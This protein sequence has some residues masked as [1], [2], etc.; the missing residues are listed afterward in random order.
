MSKIRMSVGQRIVSILRREEVKCIFSQGELSLKDIQKHA[1]DQGIRLVGPHHEAAGVWM[2]AAYYRMTGKMQV[3]MGA[4]GP[5]VA[6]MLPAV[7]WAAEER[8]PILIVG[9]SR[10]HEVTS[11]VRRGRFLHAESLM[12][13]YKEI[14]K[15]S[16]RIHHARQVDEVLQT[17]FREALSGTPGPV[18]VE[19]DYA[20]QMDEWD[21]G[22]L[23]YPENYRVIS[24]PAASTVVNQALEMVKDAKS[25]LLIGGDEIHSTRTH[26]QFHDLAQAL[27]CPVITTFGG[28]GAIKQTDP[29][30]LPYS[31][32]SGQQAIAESDLVIAVGTCIPENINYGRQRYFAIGNDKRKWMQLDP[33]PA[34]IGINRSV[35]LAIIG[36]LDSSLS[37]ITAEIRTAE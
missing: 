26:S 29:Q 20:G 9:A 5:G 36:S 31:S 22:D 25:V 32:K 11:G 15:F 8:I 19:V 33:D 18:Y 10:Q 12:G 13:C 17:A 28:A 7:V 23:N 3:A 1:I 37:Q 4:Q 30:W 16:K 34:A 14:C 2:A 27:Q 21:Y 6:N 24:Q 35:D